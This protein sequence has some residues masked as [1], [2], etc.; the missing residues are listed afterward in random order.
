MRLRGVVSTI[1][2]CGSAIAVLSVSGCAHFSPAMSP[3]RLDRGYVVVLPGIEGPSAF[4]SNVAEGLLNAE[5][6][7]AV[8]VYDWSTGSLPAFLT[9]LQDLPRNREQA[10]RLAEKII[11]Y[12]DEYPGRPVY[13]VGHSGGAGIALLTLE[14]LPDGRRIDGAILLAGAVSRDYD[15]RNALSKTTRGIWNYHSSGDWFFL[16]AGTS[17]FGTI[18]RVYA[19]SAGAYGFRV[20]DNLDAEGR[21][22]YAKLRQPP[23]RLGMLASGNYGG[24]FGP[25]TRGFARDYL[26]PV[27]ES[28]G[29]LDSR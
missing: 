6:D 24:H 12:Q 9:H 25:A 18:D 8:E 26:A 2:A 21:R 4:N 17:L 23:Y 13:L 11:R 22:Q 28:G 1:T 16:V 3:E 7:M 29:A 15:L 19:P 27:I 5:T 10:R 14:A 20:P